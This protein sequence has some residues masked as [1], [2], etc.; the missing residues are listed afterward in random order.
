MDEAAEQLNYFVKLSEHL[1]EK[2]EALEK[3]NWRLRNIIIG[4]Q[5]AR[6]EVINMIN[7]TL[8]DTQ[9]G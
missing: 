3:E 1:Q 8:K 5:S 4:I 6:D 2:A 9:G 7:R